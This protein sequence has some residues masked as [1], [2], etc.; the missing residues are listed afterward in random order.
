MN[1]VKELDVLISEG[2]D[3]QI[4]IMR[5]KNKCFRV[6]WLT[7]GK[8]RE[9]ERES[10]PLLVID[11]DRVLKTKEVSKREFNNLYIK[12]RSALMHITRR[13][14]IPSF[15]NWSSYDNPLTLSRRVKWQLKQWV[16]YFAKILFRTYLEVNLHNVNQ[17]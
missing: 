7:D 5:W 17:I 1:R 14:F 4:V 2:S 8:E 3:L 9:R 13:D 6:S 10:G 15:N 11:D 16:F 12:T